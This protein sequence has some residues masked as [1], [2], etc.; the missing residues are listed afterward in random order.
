MGVVEDDDGPGGDDDGDLA[1]AGEWGEQLLDE[2]HLGGA[3]DPQHV[4]VALLRLGGAACWRRRRR[5]VPHLCSS[6]SLQ[7]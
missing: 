6:I 5:R 1:D 2:R 4:E 3:A 7:D